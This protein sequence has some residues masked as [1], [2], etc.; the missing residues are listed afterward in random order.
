MTPSVPLTQRE[1]DVA[2]QLIKGSANKMIADELRISVETVKY[3]LRG[4]FLKLNATCRTEAAVNYL[5]ST[6][7]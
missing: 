3:Y 4:L 7:R 2:E 1:I 6:K 5:A